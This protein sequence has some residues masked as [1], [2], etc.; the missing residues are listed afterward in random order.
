MI[1]LEQNLQDSN[2]K[3]IWQ[4]LID[5]RKKFNGKFAN[6]EYDYKSQVV[7]I[8]EIKN[9][10][11]SQVKPKV[12]GAAA[13]GVALDR[14]D[15]ALFQ[16]ESSQNGEK[17]L[18]FGHGKMK[19]N[20]LFSNDHDHMHSCVSSL[21]CN[22]L[23]LIYLCWKIYLSLYLYLKL[24]LLQITPNDSEHVKSVFNRLTT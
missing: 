7:S 14:L 10:E 8:N 19:K 23:I 1:I 21:Y 15:S 13:I 22:C 4:N 24:S 16:E 3:G 20:Y 2:E 9:Q 18:D 5:G 17:I 6:R 12:Y 11:E